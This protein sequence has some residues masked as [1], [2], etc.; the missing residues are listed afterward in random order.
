MHLLSRRFTWFGCAEGK[1]LFGNVFRFFLF[2]QRMSRLCFAVWL[3]FMD[4]HF[5]RGFWPPSLVTA[6]NYRHGFYFKVLNKV[7]S[8]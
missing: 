6:V 2:Q 4:L 3:G 1:H 5:L 7:L 8:W